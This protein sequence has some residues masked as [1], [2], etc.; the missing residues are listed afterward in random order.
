MGTGIAP[1]GRVAPPT[2]Q[3]SEMT[4]F[5]LAGGASRRMGRDKAWLPVGARSLIELVIDRLAPYVNQVIVIGREPDASRLLKLEVDGVLTD[6][7]PAWGPLM[8]VYTGL[9]HTE[10]DLNL[11]VSCDMPWI[12]GR[13]IE[14]LIGAYQHGRTVVMSRHPLHG[15]QPL[16]LLCHTQA[17]RT[18]GTL[19]DRNE[20]S[21][22]A[23]I[24]QP[25]TYAA[26]IH[27]PALRRSFTN[28]N[29]LADYAI[30]AHEAA[31]A[32]RS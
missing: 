28:V 6:C 17:C 7:K 2:G 9:M 29:T 5:V 22:K 12:H 11:F 31:D 8:G 25:G 18:I 19:L 21:L 4:G 32:S 3:R 13:L 10:T 14:R 30:L 15:I 1:L 16:P 23:L 26:S 27:E 24:A 20:R